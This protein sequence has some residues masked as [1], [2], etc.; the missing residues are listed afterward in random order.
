MIFFPSF[1]CNC[2][3]YFFSFVS[4]FYWRRS[5]ANIGFS[6][7]EMW[8]GSILIFYGVES[9]K[10]VG[11]WLFSFSAVELGRTID[12]HTTAVSFLSLDKLKE[13]AFSVGCLK[14]TV[15]MES[16]WLEQHSIY[17]QYCAFVYFCRCAQIIVNAGITRGSTFI[18]ICTKN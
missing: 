7:K 2:R 1:T 17:F 3:W 15:L 14:R 11:I 5:P 6:W 8:H 4:F 16:E 10:G 13:D 9:F 12:W 18:Y